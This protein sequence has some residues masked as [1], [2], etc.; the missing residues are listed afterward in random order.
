MFFFLSF[1][2]FP[3]IRAECS[4]WRSSS[5]K[6]F[7]W[8]RSIAAIYRPPSEVFQAAAED[9]VQTHGLVSLPANSQEVE[10]S[11]LEPS[12]SWY[13][14]TLSSFCFIS[15]VRISWDCSQKCEP[16][17]FT[18]LQ[19]F[20]CFLSTSVFP[21]KLFFVHLKTFISLFSCPFT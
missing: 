7:R 12:T 10:F 16:S 11:F 15:Y 20:P 13:K 21:R 6:W 19:L 1:R 2:L 4:W 18:S 5:R 14:R 8:I 3:R 9:P 17:V